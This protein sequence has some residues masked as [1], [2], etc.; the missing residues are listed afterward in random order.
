MISGG[1]AAR[2]LVAAVAAALI[3]G[4]TTVFTTT[5]HGTATPVVL[6]PLQAARSSITADQSVDLP[7]APAASAA[8]LVPYIVDLKPLLATLQRFQDSVQERLADASRRNRATIDESRADL[9]SATQVLTMRHER[10]A[11]ALATRVTGAL[12]AYEARGNDI[13]NAA[14]QRR[15][16]IKAYAGMVE[17]LDARIDTALNGTNGLLGKLFDRTPL[18][19]LRAD[20]SDVARG[21]AILRDAQGP[22]D[23]MLQS[24]LASERRTL[25]TLDAQQK[26]LQHSQGNVWYDSMRSDIERLPA[27]RSAILDASAVLRTQRAEFEQQSSALKALIPPE[28]QIVRVAVS[29]S[30]QSGIERRSG[31]DR[32]G[33]HAGRWHRSTSGCRSA[34]CA[35]GGSSN[36][37]SLVADSRGAA[38][39]FCAAQHRIGHGG[40][41]ATTGRGDEAA[42]RRSGAGAGGARR[43]S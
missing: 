3:V 34:S 23:P 11:R 41:G 32:A 42:G 6:R 36:R 8:P 25:A 9:N 28:L 43:H 30:R 39:A 21:P 13:L 37:Q 29:H 10:L 22:D 2:V 5:A 18:I 19:Q 40:A 7:L 26:A 31:T 15:G 14:E 38:H 35:R 24:V 20:L 12:S 4:A 27:L 33:S 16:A 17:S 1:I